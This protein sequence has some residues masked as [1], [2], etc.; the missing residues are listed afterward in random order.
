MRCAVW[1]HHLSLSRYI[2]SGEKKPLQA[3][4]EHAHY[5]I[6]ELK[7]ACT[8]SVENL[9]GLDTRQNPDLTF[10]HNMGKSQAPKSHFLRKTCR[11]SP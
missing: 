10:L 5:A 2:Y 8:Y 11:P 4:A 3:A 9:S 1:W 7:T 6:D